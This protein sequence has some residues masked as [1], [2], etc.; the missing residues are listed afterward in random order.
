MDNLV[1]IAC[2]FDLFFLWD[3]QAKGLRKFFSLLEDFS[4]DAKTMVFG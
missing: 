2:T 4:S 1:V 3:L